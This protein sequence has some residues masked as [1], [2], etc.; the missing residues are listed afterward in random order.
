MV[1]L[2]CTE[3]RL[4]ITFHTTKEISLKRSLSKVEKIC[5][6]TATDL[7]I[8]FHEDRS[9]LQEMLAFGRAIIRGYNNNLCKD[10]VILTA[11]S[12]SAR[13]IELHDSRIGSM[14]AGILAVRRQSRT[15][16]EKISKALQEIPSSRKG[17]TQTRDKC[18]FLG[19]LIDHITNLQYTSKDKT[20][21]EVFS[22]IEDY[23]QMLREAK[24]EDVIYVTS[25]GGCMSISQCL[26]NLRGHSHGYNN[27]HS[28]NM[29]TMRN[30]FRTREFEKCKLGVVHYLAMAMDNDSDVMDIYMYRNF[31]Y[32]IIDEFQ[33]GENGVYPRINAIF[34][35]ILASENFHY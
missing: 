12:D 35:K 20:S 17:V 21:Q 13:H 31:S 24:E 32:Q 4:D 3:G 2:V 15:Y 23:V 1:K 30:L 11:F 33:N 28:Y 22:G 19:S 27:S 26:E 5:K 34:T 18:L 7:C 16:A 29:R 14:N 25:E 10:S 6:I 8:T 9:K